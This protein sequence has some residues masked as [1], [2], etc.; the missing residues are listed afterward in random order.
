MKN[1]FAGIAICALMATTQPF[2]DYVWEHYKIGIT[3][4][5][6]CKVVKNTDHDF[7]MKSADLDA[8][9][10]VFEKDI[11][12]EEMDEAIIETA[13]SLEMDDIEVAAEI[14]GDGLDGFFVEGTKDGHRCV[15]AGMIDPKSHTNFM[16][17]ITFLDKNETA[18]DD[19]IEIIQSVHS[20]K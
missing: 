8:L 9:M 20:L 16:L 18:V 7:E 5:D 1:L 3:V 10:Y 14:E 13:N 6:N 19:A 4:P 12:L 17:L 2:T 15:L 11:T